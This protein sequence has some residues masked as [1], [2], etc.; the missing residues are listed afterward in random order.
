MRGRT[1]A[2]ARLLA[3]LVSASVLL[4]GCLFGRPVFSREGQQPV[5]SS[6][7]T[8]PPGSAQTGTASR[9][10]APVPDVQPEGF[11]EPP[12]GQGLQRYTQQK[13]TWT[14]CEEVQCTTILVPLDY[15]DPDGQAITL[16]LSRK[17]ATAKPR[18]GSLFVN[19]GGPGASG[20]DYAKTFERKGLERYDIV[21][22][23]PRGV[24][25][26]TPVRCYEPA[27]LDTYLARDSSPDSPA[28]DEQLLEVEKA[29][30]RSC[31]AKSGRLLE[32]ISTAETARDLDLL[33]GLVK[34]DKLNYFGSSYGTQIGAVYAQVF[35]QLVGRLVLDGAVNIT[36]DKSVTQ[37]QGFERAL[38]NFAAWCA[39]RTC[40]LGESKAEVLDR[41][42]SFWAA[43]DARPMRGG[44]RPLTQQLGVTGVS[45][46]LY[47]GSWWK[48]LQQ[49][50]EL[51]I[52]DRD[53]RFMLY[54]ADSYHQRNEKTGAFGQ[55]NYSFPAVRCLDSQ[56]VDLAEARR[57]TAADNAKIPTFGPVNGPDYTCPM[58]PVAPAPKQA[59]ITGPGA[60]PIVVI[61]TTGDPATPYEYAER[62]AKQL[63]SGVLVTLKGEGHLAYGQSACIQRIVQD[64]LVQD[65]VPRDGVR[66]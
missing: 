15:A 10:V 23:D 19:P 37:A 5:P 44:R 57:K 3:V 39:E 27:E 62:M 18:I 47:Q 51:A 24:G 20:V 66:C 45:F 53:P 6:N 64:Y 59:K 65:K 28:E 35:P 9:P 58:W 40:K 11:A 33:R 25:S 29:F 50:L 17:P 16:A 31:L 38:G 7:A 1:A 63:S 55:L 30:G 54:L 12:P 22:W 21:G 56:D 34:D 2:T 52:F 26:S 48:Y 46:V 14:E 32:H 60:A 49:A 43:L 61:G 8:T 41:I 4:G 36:E 42:G 13:L